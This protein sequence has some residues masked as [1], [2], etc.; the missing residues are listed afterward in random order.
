MLHPLKKLSE[1]ILNQNPWSSFRHD[2]YEKPNGKVGDYYYMQS[3]GFVIVIPQ[4]PNGKFLLVKQYRYLHQQVGI[5]FPAG[6]IIRGTELVENAKRELQEETGYIAKEWKYVGWV[7]PCVGLIKDREHIFFASLDF[8]EMA[9]PDDTEEI[10]WLELSRQE[11]DEYIETG[12]IWCG[13]SISAWYRCR[14]FVLN[15]ISV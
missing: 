5:S 2:T 10:E 1:E 14:S 7:E 6:G 13:Q 12:K 9:L 3:P 4:L 11:V 15:N 8:Q